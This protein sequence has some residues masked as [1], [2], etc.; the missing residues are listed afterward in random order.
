[1]IRGLVPAEKLLEW[2]VEDGWEPLCKFLDKDVPK[3]D[4]PHANTRGEG[5]AAREEQ[6]TSLW[7]GT[8]LRN[9]AIIVG[10]LALG[11]VLGYRQIRQQL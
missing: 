5:W 3:E 9:L 7:V 4:F 1:M 10:S 6:A 2:S 8:A 11:G